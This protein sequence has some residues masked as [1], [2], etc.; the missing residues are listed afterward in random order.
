MNSKS[1]IICIAGPSGS[2]KTTFAKNL[3]SALPNNQTT[4]I[5]QDAYYK[6]LSHLSEDE[7]AIQN[8]DHPQSLDFKLLKEHLIDLLNGHAISQPLY[9]FN[10]HS[11]LKSHTS[12]SPTKIIIVEGTLVLSEKPLLDLFDLKIYIDLDQDTCLARRINRDIA[13]R[14]RTKESVINQY[15]QTVK[16]MF[17]EFISPSKKNADWVIPGQSN[18]NYI[19]TIIKEIRKKENLLQ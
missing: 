6:D 13:E 2:G 10:T 1:I 16:P 15:K 17:E 11:R 14:G 18:D 9:D 7:K 8:F 19:E 3:I 5:S 12:V 4:L